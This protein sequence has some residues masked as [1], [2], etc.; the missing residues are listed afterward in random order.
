MGFGYKILGQSAPTD[1]NNANLYTVPS[2]TEA[3]ISTIAVANTTSTDATYRIFV[4]NNGATAAASNAL[5][6]DATATAN[7][8]TTISVGITLD[9][10]DVVS[11]R[12]ATA[13]ALTF[14]AFGTEVT[15]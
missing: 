13:N 5:V 1:T 12:S 6:Y 2:S 7:T 3:V 14:H 11:V 10:S 4:R 8:T 15:V 9:A